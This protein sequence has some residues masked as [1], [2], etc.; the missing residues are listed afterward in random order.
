MTVYDLNREQL[1]ELKQAYWIGRHVGRQP[2]MYTLSNIDDIVSDEQVFAAY[3]NYEFTDDD[4]VCSAGQ[5]EDAKC[6]IVIEGANPAIVY[7]DL[8]N[9][10]QEIENGF[11]SGTLSDGATWYIE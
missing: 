2:D 7:Y 3:H 1:I 11:T 4:F 5:D 9:V 8:H 10:A 6:R